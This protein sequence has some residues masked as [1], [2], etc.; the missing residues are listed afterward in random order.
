MLKFGNKEFRNL[1]EQ[2]YKN[3]KDIASIVSGS[4][5]LAEFGIRVVGQVSSV[6][7]MP[8]VDAYKASNPDWEYGD[9][10]A[11]GSESPYTLY[12]LTR[13]D[14]NHLGDYWFDIGEFPAVGPQ[15]PQGE[16][17]ET[18]PQGPQGNPGSNGTSAGF[19]TITAT[20]HTLDPDEDASIS[21]TT[22]G[23]NTALNIDFEFGIPQGEPGED[24]SSGEWGSIT[25]DI[26]DQS[27][28]I[29]LLQGKQNTLVSGTNIKTINNESILGSGNIDIQGGGGDVT[30]VEVN[31][32]SVVDADG[33]AQ[34]DLTGYATTS[35][36]SDMATETWVGNQGFLTSVS[37]S[38]VSDKPTF[39]TV[40]TSGS[41]NDLS[42]KPTIPAA[43]VNSDWDAVSGVAQILNKPDLSI[44]AESADLATVAT[45]GDY[46]DLLNKPVIPVVNY[47]VT[48]VEVNGTSVLSG[49]VAEV[50]VPT[51]TGDLTNNAGYITGITSS[52]VTTALGYTPADSSDLSDYVTLATAQTITGKKTFDNNIKV[53]GNPAY[54]ET[55][56]RAISLLKDSSTVD[57]VIGTTGKNNT[58]GIWLAASDDGSPTS[59]PQT[60]S[61]PHIGVYCKNGLLNYLE[62][63]SLKINPN[64]NGY[65]LELPSTSAYAANKTIATTDQIPAAQVNA[66]WNAVS[67]VAQILNKP[68]IPQG[69]DIITVSGSSGTLSADDLARITASPETILI[70]RGNNFYQINTSTDSSWNYVWKTISS[71]IDYRR[72]VTITKSTGAWTYEEVTLEPVVLTGAQTI[73]GDK[74]FSGQ[75]TFSDA[76]TITAATTT[77]TIKPSSNNLYN[78]GTSTY[79]WH[80]LY[81]NGAVN[82]NSNNYGLVFPSTASYTANRTIA[83]LDDITAGGVTDVEVDNVS[84]VTSGVA[85]LTSETW[86]FTLSDGTTTTKKILVG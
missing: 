32:T 78:L 14:E 31:G 34:I 66:D 38:D 9:A 67:G 85:E 72:S 40:A 48:D 17:G 82:R 24:G 18:G 56:A 1:Q 57:G 70:Q 73:A 69:I 79:G 36:I 55:S 28:L 26:E 50:T 41:Y 46:D 80:D 20:A 16:Q 58:Y 5:V 60:E 27:D 13:A 61:D 8:T 44:Y 76:V 33:V 15:G 86:T 59:S 64:S 81:L 83:T 3:M 35:D 49:T 77:R 54:P 74:T 23:P 62:I 30:D 12:V 22:S 25:G 75:T 4:A 21:I 52:D 43:Q 71:G 53:I 84:V 2:V 11:V 37:W 7:N 47:P 10:Y 63:D 51:D 39:A 6:A 19:G 42:N 65:G 45:T 68:T 29:T